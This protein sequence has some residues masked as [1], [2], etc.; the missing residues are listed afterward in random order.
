[1]KLAATVIVSMAGTMLAAME[2]Q[3]EDGQLTQKSKQHW[4]VHMG[5]WLTMASQC[6]EVAHCLVTTKGECRK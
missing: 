3:A 5:R 6:Q 2:S 4:Y 1:M